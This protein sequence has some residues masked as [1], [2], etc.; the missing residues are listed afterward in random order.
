[1]LRKVLVV[2]KIRNID[3]LLEPEKFSKEYSRLLVSAAMEWHV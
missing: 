3:K 2:N 1:M